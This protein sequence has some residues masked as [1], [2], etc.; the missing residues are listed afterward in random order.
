MSQDPIDRLRRAN[1]LPD[2]PVAPPIEP[3][4]ER[5]GERDRHGSRAHADGAG[6]TNR[7]GGLRAGFRAA[8]VAFAAVL[9]IA[10]AVLALTLLRH[11]NPSGSPTSSPGF[12]V[13]AGLPPV[14]SLS[15]G[16]MHALDYHWST[17]P[18]VIVQGNA[19]SPSLAKPPP[20]PAWYDQGS[21]SQALLGDYAVLQS[22][23]TS[24]VAVLSPLLGGGHWAKYG[25]IAQHRYGNTIEVIPDRYIEHSER[26][27]TTRCEKA[28]LAAQRADL[29][30]APAALIARALQLD[31][32]TFED[33]RYIQQHPDGICVL[34][35]GGGGCG[36]FLFA[37]ARGSLTTVA[38]GSHGSLNAYLVP[39]GVAKISVDYSAGRP[40]TAAERTVAPPTTTV[41]VINNVAVWTVPNRSNIMT[42]HAIAWLT[43]TGKTLRTAYP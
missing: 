10:I 1:P 22:R 32:Q 38:Y 41:P 37:Q 18:H 12:H 30:G 34:V 14:P 9:S 5:L 23:A 33:E 25:R 35:D 7:L 31:R 15:P 11:H 19:C 2:P 40:H 17:R 39:N 4:L 26:P 36:P 20:P 6:G 8:P 13:P 28:Q 3:L 27:L 43:T 16:D 21:P 24:K 42:P 29:A